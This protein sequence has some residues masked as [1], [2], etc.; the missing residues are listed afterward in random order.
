MSEVEEKIRECL[1]EI[2]PFSI[3]APEIEQAARALRDLENLVKDLTK[4]NIEKALRM[5]AEFYQ[6][7]LPY[8]N[9]LPTTVS[10][11]KFI[12]EWLEKKKT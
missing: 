2:E 11:L 8:S 7:A 4:E 3:F 10:N 9:Y 1:A 5:V 6:E 12:K